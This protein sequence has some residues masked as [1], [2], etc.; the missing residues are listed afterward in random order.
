M[1]ISYYHTMVRVL[2]LDTSL[3]FYKLLGLEEKRRRDDEKGRYTNVF[4][5]SPGSETREFVERQ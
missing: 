1:T 5:G 3:A 4:L 2:D